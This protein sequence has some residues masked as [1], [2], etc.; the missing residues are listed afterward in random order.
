M[1]GDKNSTELKRG[2]A[3]QIAA[4][5]A[6]LYAAGRYREA[7][8]QFHLAATLWPD[9]ADICYN[10]ALSDWAMGDL[11]STHAELMR[12]LAIDSNYAKAYD[13]LAR[14]AIN[15]DDAARAHHF[16]QNAIRLQPGEAEFVLTAANAL[17][18]NRQFGQTWDL[19]EPMALEPSISERAAV[20]YIRLSKPLHR[21]TQAIDFATQIIRRP[22]VHL[23]HRRSL[24]FALAGLYDK[25]GRHDDA[26]ANAVAAHEINRP[27]Y[28]AVARRRE[29]DLRINHWTADRI[30]RVPRAAPSNRQPV[31][32]VGMPRSGTS[33]IEQILSQHP[34]VYAAGE[35]SAM[36]HAAAALDRFGKPYPSSLESI[37][38][39][40]ADTLANLY[41]DEVALLDENKRLFT[42][43]MPLNFMYLELVDRLLPNA[44]V[45]H[46]IRDHRDTCLS[47]FMTDFATPYDFASSIED[48]GEFYGMYERIMAHWKRVLTIPILDV[49]YEEVV[50]DLESQSRRILD[51][52]ELP[53]DGR[54]L[55]FHESDRRVVTASKDQVRQPLYRSSVGRWK[56]YA[57][58]LT[59]LQR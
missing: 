13:A 46:C 21:E 26:F 16:S 40:D 20:L 33:L 38:H 7:V 17:E 49:R 11:Q 58:H 27:A 4:N 47:C 6:A 24:H 57:S 54:C 56:N 14:M 32:I 35:L 52:L 25:I 53:W 36:A 10:L 12:V 34:D 1:S 8:G 55:Q 31:F 48:L 43:K 19:I 50:D 23:A 22:S 9:Q 29:F 44:K 45:I 37:T 2:Q 59:A 39:A 51:F 3:K 42:D 41:L 15:A 5:A 18:M 30:N 28:D